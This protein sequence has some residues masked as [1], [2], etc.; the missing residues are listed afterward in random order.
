MDIMNT[1]NFICDRKT[2]LFNQ[3]NLKAIKRKIVKRNEILHE[4][5]ATSTEI[6]S[7]FFSVNIL[8][9]LGEYFIV[10]FY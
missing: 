10:L 7:V 3:F 5:L 9:F 1:G 2:E 4:I 8:N 6:K